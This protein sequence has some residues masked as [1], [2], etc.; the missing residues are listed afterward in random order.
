MASKHLQWSWSEWKY[1]R[2]IK[3]CI[4]QIYNEKNVKYLNNLEI[5][6]MFI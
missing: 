2:N 6:F 1:A 3:Y 4:L 5:D